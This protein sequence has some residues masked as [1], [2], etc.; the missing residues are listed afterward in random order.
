MPESQSRSADVLARRL[1]AA[2]IDV[3]LARHEN[4]GGFLAEGGHHPTG[5]PGLLDATSGPG[6][7]NAANVGE[8]AREDRVPPIVGTGCIDAETF[9]EIAAET[10]K[11]AHDVRI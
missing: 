9:T 8:T 2:G 3:A 7:M 10:D 4:A 6:T 5:A 1:H 11:R